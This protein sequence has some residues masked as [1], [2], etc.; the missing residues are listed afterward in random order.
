MS[1]SHSKANAPLLVALF[2]CLPAGVFAQSEP[3]HNDVDQA[4]P[5]HVWNGRSA[6][7]ANGMPRLSSSACPRNPLQCVRWVETLDRPS[8]A[9]LTQSAPRRSW[10][11]R[12]PVIFG[13]LVGFGTG[14]LVGLAGGDDGIF[15]D[16]TAEFNGM[17]VGGIGAGIGAAVGAAVSAA[18]K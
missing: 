2:V 3:S 6:A 5:V 15:D 12:H 1:A 7:V 4:S 9:Q 16:F 17:V 13:T 10:I 8:V 14:F 18:S 11:A